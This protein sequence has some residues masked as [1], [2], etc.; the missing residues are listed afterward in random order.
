[1]VAGASG[2]PALEARTAA[3]HAEPVTAAQITVLSMA[4]AQ[5]V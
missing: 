3:L 1:M 5:R 2:C 4:S